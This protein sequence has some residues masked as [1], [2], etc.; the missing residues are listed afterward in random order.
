MV[1][2]LLFGIIANPLQ[3]SFHIRSLAPPHP[4]AYQVFTPKLTPTLPPDRRSSPKPKAITPKPRLRPSRPQPPATTTDTTPAKDHEN[5]HHLTETNQVP[6]LTQN[7]IP[8]YPELA[9]QA[10]IES[11][12]LI[13]IIIDVKGNVVDATVIYVSNPG[14]GFE[15]NALRAVRQLKFEPLYESGNA[16]NYKIVYPINFVLF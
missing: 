15:K 2:L 7:V 6:I 5:Q 4:R 8:E 14:F 1:T 11:N 9:Q 10:G 16:I 3:P 12:V 13:E